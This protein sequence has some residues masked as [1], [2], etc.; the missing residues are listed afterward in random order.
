[1]EVLAS[2]HLGWIAMTQKSVRLEDVKNLVKELNVSILM[3]FFLPN[4]FWLPETISN[5][6]IT[7]PYFMIPCTT[8]TYGLCL[9]I[10]DQFW[11]QIC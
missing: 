6:L 2:A 9:D 11:Y 3:P 10:Y 8:V 5:L 1:M 7:E 4:R